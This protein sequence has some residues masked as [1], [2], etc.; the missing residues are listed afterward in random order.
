MRRRSSPGLYARYSAN[1]WLKPKSGERCRPA[2]KPSTTV[3]ATRSRPEIPARILGSRNRCT[4]GSRGRRHGLEQAVQDL[5][6]I[7][8]IRLRVEVQQDAMPE[9]GDGQ[10]SDVVVGDV[11]TAARQGAGLGSQ[12]D[13]LRGANA[14]AVVDVLLDEVGRQAA[15]MARGANQIDDVASQGFG[16]GDHAHKLLEIENLLGIGYGVDMGDARG[17]GKVH[18][19]YFVFGA[20]VIENGIEEKAVELRFG[21]RVGAFELD[22]VLRGQD[23]KGRG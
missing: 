14:G 20:Q 6:R 4:S 10:R 22:G 13:E 12:Y 7:D 5:V 23:E 19:F 17:R 1:S 11:I 16:D 9:H 21:Q 2:T 3:L 18:N 8:A 15:V